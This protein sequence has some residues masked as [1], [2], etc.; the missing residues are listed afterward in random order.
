MMCVCVLVAQSRLTLCDPMDSSPPVSSV[1]V[2]FQARI[3][4]GVAISFSMCLLYVTPKYSGWVYMFIT[5][6]AEG[7]KAILFSIVSPLTVL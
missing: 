4:E 7:T 2:L 5:V 1:H 3:L 6:L